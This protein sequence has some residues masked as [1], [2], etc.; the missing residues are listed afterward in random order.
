M[1]LIKGI[2]VTLID[3]VEIGRD[4]FGRPVYEDKPIIVE[5]VLVS[6]TSAD[7]VV[8]QLSISG[9]TAVYTLG[10]PKGDK[11]IWEDR[12]VEFFGRKWKSFGIPLEGMEDL[13]PLD[14]N[15][16]V[17]VERYE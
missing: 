15:K 16:K 17:M 7:D 2:E 10:I 13:M 4:P 5:N 12:E 14:W 3:K 9:K 8:S 11:N 1:G 6:P